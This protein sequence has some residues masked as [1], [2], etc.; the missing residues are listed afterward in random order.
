MAGMEYILPGI[1]VVLLGL[2]L[3]LLLKQRKGGGAVEGE[4][5]RRID[6]LEQEAEDL[7]GDL[8]AAR[9]ARVQAETRLEAERKSFEEKRRLLA[10]AETQLKDAFAALSAKALKEGREQFLGEAGEHLKPIRQVLDAYQKRLEEIEKARNDAYGGLT[11]R[12]ATLAQAHQALQKEAHQLSTA[13]RSPTVRGR[14]GEMALRNVIEAAGMNPHCDFEEQVSATG[15]AGRIRPD[16]TVHLPNDR[17]VVVD[18]KAPLDAYMEAMEAG[19]ESS[20]KAALDR[21][22]RALRSHVQQLCLKAY[23]QQF[24]N[25]PDFVVLFI[26]GESFFSAALEAD[27]ALLEDALRSKVILASPATLIALLRAVASGWQEEALAE[28]AQ[29]IGQTGR[30]LYDRVRVFLEHFAKAG[31]ALRQ[32]TESYNSAVG[33][34]ESRVRP[35]AQRL[36]EQAAADLDLPEPKRIDASLRSLPEPEADEE[37]P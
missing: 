33:S 6:T 20:R 21:H 4:L 14:W 37:E 25:T 27:R 29:R 24:E 22:A 35:S 12:L 8:G 30:E 26:P 15:E 5:R 3:A 19:D 23:W 34:Y 10:D 32:A 13:L 1:A 16:V 11:S 18:A 2:V 17:I 36:A 7:R 9:Q 31:K 28:N